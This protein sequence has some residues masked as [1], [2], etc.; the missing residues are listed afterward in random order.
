MCTIVANAI[1]IA[2]INGIADESNAV[3]KIFDRLA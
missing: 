3:F 1:E 2:I